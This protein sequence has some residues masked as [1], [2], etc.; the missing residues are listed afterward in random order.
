MKKVLVIGG[1]VALALAA[2]SAGDL[3][4]YIRIRSM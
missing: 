4:R 1:I 3:K 2:V